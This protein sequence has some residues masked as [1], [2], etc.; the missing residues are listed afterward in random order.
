[1]TMQKAVLASL[2]L[3]GLH[4]SAGAW[5]PPPAAMPRQAGW[6]ALP[7]SQAAASTGQQR[8]RQKLEQ[9]V[10]EV[11]GCD[12]QILAAAEAYY[13]QQVCPEGHDWARPHSQC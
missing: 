9:R 13:E 4:A 8:V 7:G 6:P 3:G 12:E 10:A 5:L 1:M 11:G 2:L